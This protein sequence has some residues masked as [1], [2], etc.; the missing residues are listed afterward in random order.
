MNLNHKGTSSSDLVPI[1]S[2]KAVDIE[3]F[4]GCTKNSSVTY[5]GFLKNCFRVQEIIIIHNIAISFNIISSN[6]IFRYWPIY[7]STDN[8]TKNAVKNMRINLGM[9]AVK[10]YQIYWLYFT[11]SMVCNE[12]FFP[13]YENDIEYVSF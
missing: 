1:T 2:I 9:V 4:A 10:A 12:Y 6:Y 8:D 3:R 5:F 7:S 13:Y 11:A